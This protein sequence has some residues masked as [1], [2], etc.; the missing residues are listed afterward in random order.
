ME[1]THVGGKRVTTPKQF[2]DEVAGQQGPVKLLLF[3]ALANA[4]SASFRPR[5]AEPHFAAQIC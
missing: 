4:P 2:R 3:T 5:R 1:I